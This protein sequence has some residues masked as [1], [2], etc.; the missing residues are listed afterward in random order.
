MNQYNDYSEP[1]IRQNDFTNYL[2]L[3]KSIFPDQWSFLRAT[4]DIQAR[5][6]NY[7][8]EY[9]EQQIFMV[10][11]NLQRLANFQV[12]RHWVMVIATAY[13]GWGTKDTV[14]NAT[15]F[16]GIRVS[17][18]SRDNFF[19]ELTVNW[20]NVFRSLLASRRSGLMVWDNFQR[21]QEIQDQRGGRSSKFFIG[22]VEAVHCVVPFIDIQLN[23][24][25][26]FM[27]YDH[28]QSRPS[29]LGMRRYESLDPFSPTFGSDIFLNHND[30]DVPN[31]P[32]FFGD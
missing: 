2:E 10:L 32:C 25:N 21:G 15:S 24:H 23:D 13:Y 31:S 6:G 16:L 30:I 18:R 5:D 4:R 19:K 8:Q 26:V 9:K 20:V 27:R 12:L 11:L 7:Q 22:T 3:S 14:S 1:L 28:L 29:P 17:R